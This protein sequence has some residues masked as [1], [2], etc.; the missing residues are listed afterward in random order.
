MCVVSLLHVRDRR[1]EN[2]DTDPLGEPQSERV[3]VS[4]R[5]TMIIPAIEMPLF[6]RIH[7]TGIVVHLSA[8][9]R[10]FIGNLRERRE[11]IF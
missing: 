10:R 11:F 8:T 2:A 6:V 3:L 5:R 7:A 9:W 1:K 4:L